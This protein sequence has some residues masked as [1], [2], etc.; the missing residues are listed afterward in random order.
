M[1]GTK[2]ADAAHQFINMALSKEIQSQLVE[3]LQAGPVNVRR[4]RARQARASPASS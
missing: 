3:S 2:R 4:H 1:A